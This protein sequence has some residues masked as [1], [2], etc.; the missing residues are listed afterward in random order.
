M[1]TLAIILAFVVV[2]GFFVAIASNASAALRTDYDNGRVCI[3]WAWYINEATGD[4]YVKC[5]RYS[6]PAQL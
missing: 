1:K 3:D 4:A 2:S 6:S 5:V